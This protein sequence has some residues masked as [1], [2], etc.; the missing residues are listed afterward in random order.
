MNLSSIGC[1]VPVVMLVRA[2]YFQNLF[3]NLKVEGF[4][5]PMKKLIR[6]KLALDKN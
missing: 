4:F 2:I 6:S 3:S 1:E 5:G